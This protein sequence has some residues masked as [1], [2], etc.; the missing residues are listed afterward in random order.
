[1]VLTGSLRRRVAHSN[2]RRLRTSRCGKRKS[3]SHCLSNAKC[4]WTIG[5]K[6]S[7]CRRKGNR[8][9]RTFRRHNIFRR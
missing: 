8:L 2:R 9:R 7:F 6:R 3:K 1:M 5:R 4:R